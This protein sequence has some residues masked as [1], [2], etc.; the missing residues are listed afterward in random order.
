M[1]EKNKTKRSGGGFLAFVLGFLLSVAFGWVVFPDML[2]SEREQ[3]IAFSHKIHTEDQGL[4]CD[5]CHSF[6]EDGSYQGLPTNEQCTGCHAEQV[7]QTPAEAKYVQEY[8]QK[9]KE[10]P[11]LT[12]QYQPDNVL[13]SHKVHEP[14]ECTECHI[15]LAKADKAPKYFENKLSGYSKQTMKMWQCERC[16]AENGV[17][18]GCHVCHK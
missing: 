8:V 15:D 16:H 12:Y 6:R 3:P 17:G 9:N 11:W 5:T 14:F 2:F 4:S 7:G 18:N 10:V 1:E 13:F